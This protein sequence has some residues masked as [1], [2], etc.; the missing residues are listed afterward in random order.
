MELVINKCFGGFS[1]SDMACKALGL[2]SPYDDID[3]DNHELIKVV[4]KMGAQ[5]D[6]R[7]AKLSIVEIPFEATDWH[8][9]EYDGFE[10][11]VYVVDGKL[12]WI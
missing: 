5:A 6:G 10:S 2:S 12:H 11:V 9:D 8:I 1:L 7:N 4:R 3:R